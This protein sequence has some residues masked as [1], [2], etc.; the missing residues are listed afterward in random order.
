L[1]ELARV[2][3]DDPNYSHGF[4]VP[5]VSGYLAYQYVRRVGGSDKGN[6]PA[7]L[8][9]LTGGC[10][11]HL[12]AVLLWWPPIDLVALVTILHGLAILLG[13]REWARGLR[14]PIR[15]LFFLFPLPVVLTE[16]LAITLQDVVAGLS[17]RVLALFLPAHRDGYK[18]LVPGAQ[19]E[20]GEACSGL[21]QLMAFV[22]LTLIVVHLSRRSRL[23]KGL[24]LVSDAGGGGLEPAARAADGVHYPEL[25]RP[26]DQPQRERDPRRRLLVPRCLG[27][28]DD[29]RRPPP[30]AGHRLVA[31]ARAA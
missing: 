26:L 4:L 17:T 21:R 2:W 29:G 5:L 18:I 3:L 14:F 15:F 1:L 12:A 9:W 28:A 10:W 13:G 23:F 20:V 30:A 22:A 6:V 16:R 8:V 11:L 27:P 25:R 19:L 7:G 31:G 24:L